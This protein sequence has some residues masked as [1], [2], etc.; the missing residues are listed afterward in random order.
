MTSEESQQKTSK[1]PLNT[2]STADSDNSTDKMES[3]PSH[4]NT[5]VTSEIKE[6][7]ES[8]ISSDK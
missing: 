5:S 3:E 1:I 7:T 4:K 2:T 8:S 6:S